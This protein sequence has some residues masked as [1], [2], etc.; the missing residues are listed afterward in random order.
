MKVTG[1]NALIADI[2][3]YKKD[4]I[5]EIK[6]VVFDTAKSVE[7]D[8][9]R[10]APQFIKSKID[11]VPENGGLTAIVGV[12]GSDPLPAYFEFG[13]GLS[14]KEILAP[15]PQWVKNIAMQ[16][17]VNGQGVLRGRPFLYPALLK[18]Q[19]QFEED[20]Q[21]VLDENKKI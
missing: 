16:F 20:I 21:K 4:T 3:K 11:T 1:L 19:R 15:Y 10:S 8:A 12:Q 6:G 17:Y 18:A 7:L 5:D 9:I 13:T 14:A 2:E